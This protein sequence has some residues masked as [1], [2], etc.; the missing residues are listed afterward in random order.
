[1]QKRP[2]FAVREEIEE[3]ESVYT[4]ERDPSAELTPK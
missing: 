1:M 2:P 3:K 4:E